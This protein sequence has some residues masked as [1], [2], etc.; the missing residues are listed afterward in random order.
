MV[1]DNH[2]AHRSNE[3]VNFAHSLGI[4]ILFMPPTASELN[5]IERM[6]SYFKRRWRQKLYDPE[7]TITNDNSIRFIE[8]TLQEVAGKC[9]KLARGPMDHMRR[10][11]KP[12]NW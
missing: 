1:M 3:T 8:E 2:A 4:E 7:L 6:W 11:C 5:P 12:P 10:W 9:V